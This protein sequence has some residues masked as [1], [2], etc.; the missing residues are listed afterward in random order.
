MLIGA[1][2][3]PAH[4]VL[5]EIEWMAGMGLDF[6]DLTLEPP[7]AASW[8][9][10]PHAIRKALDMHGMQ[11]VG[12]TAFY[13]PIASAIE[14]IRRASVCE[15]RRCLEA[16]S[17]VGARWMN[18]HP[19]RYA[20][21]HDRRFYI[22]QNIRSLQELLPDARRL[23]VGLMIEN[24]PGDYNNAAQ[25]GELLN[26]LPELGLHLDIGHANLEVPFNTTEE[27]L[28]AYGSRLRHVHLHDNKGGHADLHL[29][30]GS[31]ALDLRRAIRALL[32]AGYDG[33]IT[34]EV[35]TPDRHY[36]AYSRDVLRQMWDEEAPG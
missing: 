28:R 4:D 19:D 1:M 6:L 5:E 27:I 16:F 12:H 26:Q 14:D 25:L 32:A 10:D 22:G 9:I 31:G 35:F 30:L 2:N 11:V 20:P 36:L 29:P 8:R 7:A 23:A 24:L 21:M 15:L 34:L 33:T 18:V 17:I 3:H 13:L